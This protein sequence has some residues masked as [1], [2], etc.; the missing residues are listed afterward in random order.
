MTNTAH[1][2]LSVSD[3]ARE[4]YRSDTMT[5]RHSEIGTVTL[6]RVGAETKKA[7]YYF[8]LS[9]DQKPSALQTRLPCWPMLDLNAEINT[10]AYS[11]QGSPTEREESVRLTSSFKH[12]V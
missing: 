7:S 10:Q 12:L 11:N 4:S 8:R 2:F 5:V 3:E 9:S 1:L 6:S